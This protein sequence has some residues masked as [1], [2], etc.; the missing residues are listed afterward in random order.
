MTFF[1]TTWVDPV[2][3]PAGAMAKLLQPA[4]LLPFAFP[5]ITTP[6]TTGGT[7]FGYLARRVRRSRSRRRT[8]SSGVAA[9]ADPSVLLSDGGQKSSSG[10]RVSAGR[11]WK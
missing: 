4:A 5:P 2:S 6:L 7:P 9:H 8:P 10:L 11:R 3:V 1:V